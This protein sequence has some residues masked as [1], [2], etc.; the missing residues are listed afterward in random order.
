MPVAVVRV[1]GLPL[2]DRDEVDRVRRVELEPGGSAR[3]SLKAQEVHVESLG[4][5]PVL[6][7]QADMVD[8][9]DVE[10]H[11]AFLARMVLPQSA[12][13]RGFDAGRRPGMGLPVA[14]FASKESLHL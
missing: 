12:Y 14:G 3:D 6:H 2:P 10:L 4:A 13:L 7:D 1:F 8:G 5:P 9:L 11:R